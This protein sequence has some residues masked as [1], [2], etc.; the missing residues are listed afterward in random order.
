MVLLRA[1]MG[2]QRVKLYLRTYV[3][4]NCIFCKHKPV[5]KNANM[6]HETIFEVVYKYELKSQLY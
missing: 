4:R 2:Q 3:R 5:R 6:R 1:N